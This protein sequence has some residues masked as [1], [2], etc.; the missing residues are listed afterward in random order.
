M[1]FNAA[2]SPV[3]IIKAPR[4]SGMTSHGSKAQSFSLDRLFA[5]LLLANLRPSPSA[6]NA[7]SPK[8]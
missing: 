4:L 2:Q 6:L 7:L 8:P 5:G 3:V 1:I